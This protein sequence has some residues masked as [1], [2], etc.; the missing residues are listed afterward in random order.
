[1]AEPEAFKQ[2]VMAFYQEARKNKEL[3]KRAMWGTWS[4][5]GRA[6]KSKTQ[7]AFNFKTATSNLSPSSRIPL[8]SGTCSGK[9]TRGV[10][11]VLSM[12]QAGDD[13]GSGI[14][15]D[16]QR[17]EHE[18]MALVGSNCGV[19]DLQ[20]I[21][22]ANYLCNELGMDTITAGATISC[23]ME[24]FEIGALSEKDI[25]YPLGFGN[26]PN[27][28]RALKETALRQGFGDVLAEGGAAVA[29]KYGRP[30]LFMG[31]K[32]R[33]CPP[34]IPRES[35]SSVFSMPPAM[36]AP[37]TPRPRCPST[38][39]GWTRCTT[40]SGRKRIRTMW[41]SWI[42]E[43]SAGSFTTARCGTKSHSSG[44]GSPRAWITRQRNWP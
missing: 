41:P 34:G 13:Q 29:E 42:R 31:V 20:D 1:V 15:V 9:E 43:C 7:A 12:L 14:S 33:V 6:N 16:D 5:P 40:W 22:R 35:R 17:P 2:A 3:E 36:W 28:F 23:A 27:M 10:S 39:G 26:A 8:T 25:G 32:S 11:P 24:L 38:R 37:A 18:T 30:E 21:Y 19:G 44:S 4:L